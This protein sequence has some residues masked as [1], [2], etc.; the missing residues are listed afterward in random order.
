MFKT[1]QHLLPDGRA[2]STTVQK[3]LRSFIKGVS[4]S[5]S[6]AKTSLDNVYDEI[7]P[8]TTNSLDEWNDQFG[9]PRASLTTEQMRSRLSAAWKAQGGQD[10]EYIQSTLRAAGFDVYVHEW[11][12]PGTEPALGVH[13][14]ATPRNPFLYLRED[15]GNQYTILSLGDELAMCGESFAQCGNSTT[16]IGYPLVNKVYY[17]IPDVIIQLG[18]TYA[19]C[20]EP[21]ALM[22]N[23]LT[24]TQAVMKY[25]I[26]TDQDTWHHFLYIGGETFG[27]VATVPSARRD[28]FEALCLK[29][30]PLQ[31]WIGLIV[32]YG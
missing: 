10:P 20:G 13:G 22:N 11:W 23:A 6:D 12:E 28:E 17:S 8:A 2:F 15:S 5:G 7:S 30:C 29:I 26:P 4:E 1:L 16:P 3:S 24:Y 27:D 25:T 31:L 19:F 32:T 21:D 18:E 9:L 14:A